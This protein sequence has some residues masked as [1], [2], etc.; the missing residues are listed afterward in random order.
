[1]AANARAPRANPSSA[2]W[3]QELGRRKSSVSCPGLAGT[4]ALF[5]G[6]ECQTDGRSSNSR[7]LLAHDQYTTIVRSK[8]AQKVL[9][10]PKW[11]RPQS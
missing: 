5:S 1:M 8:P 10:H 9:N 4:E 3:K 2:R 7:G 11:R 6:S